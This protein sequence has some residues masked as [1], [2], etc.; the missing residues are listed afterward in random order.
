MTVDEPEPSPAEPEEKTQDKEHGDK[1]PEDEERDG[2]RLRYGSTLGGGVIKAPTGTGGVFAWTGRL[3]LQINHLFGI[4]YQN[5]P[6]LTLTP[7]STDNSAGFEA[8]FIDYNS[9][10]ASFTLFHVLDFG[11]GPSMDYVAVASCS[12]TLAGLESGA[13]CAST[14]DWYFGAHARGALILG[15]LS[16]DGPRRSGF[17]LAA[18]LHP[19]FLPEGTTFS[20]T[21]GLGGEWY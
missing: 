12:A 7:E 9:L 8:G 13:G 4:Y 11:A 21:L 2:V 5:T 20:F 17:A 3:G 6:M 1:E 16:G 18:E 14:S 19:V 15:G 10:L